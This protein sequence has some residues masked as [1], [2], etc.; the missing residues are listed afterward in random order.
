MF[1]KLRG[2]IRDWWKPADSNTDRT[3]IKF[4][5]K[6]HPSEQ[7]ERDNEPLLLTTKQ[8]RWITLG[9]NR[10]ERRARYARLKLLYRQHNITAKNFK[11][12]MANL[13]GTTI[14]GEINFIRFELQNSPYNR[15]SNGG[16]NNP[17]LRG[18]HERGYHHK[19][20]H[21]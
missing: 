5:P 21:R 14:A 6:A 13:A 12:V 20:V 1:E 9:L 18:A 19:K 4:S 3:P 8:T 10:R 17:I 15:P 7:L 16:T 11:K 2:R